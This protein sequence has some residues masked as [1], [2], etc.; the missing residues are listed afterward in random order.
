MESGVGETKEKKQLNSGQRIQVPESDSEMSGVNEQGSDIHEH[1]D[2]SGPSSSR[3]G[4]RRQIPSCYRRDSD[5]DGNDGTL[6]TICQNN[7]PERLAYSVV[8]WVD[9]SKCGSWVH[10]V[11]AFGSNA[12]SRQYLCPK[13]SSKA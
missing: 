4:R 9:C 8:F 5:S 3:F 1:G 12:V 2:D 13:C 10:N 7:E 6:C 11:C